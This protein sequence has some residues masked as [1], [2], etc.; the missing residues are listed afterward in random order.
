MLYAPWSVACPPDREGRRLREAA[1]LPLERSDLLACGGQVHALVGAPLGTDRSQHNRSRGRISTCRAVF[2][3]CC[4]LRSCRR[5]G[6]VPDYLSLTM[7]E[8]SRTQDPRALK[9]PSS[10]VLGLENEAK[11]FQKSWRPYVVTALEAC[12]P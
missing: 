6:T 8:E 12:K 4:C 3:I 2:A 5:E 11:A 9:T 7:G 1:T 10:G